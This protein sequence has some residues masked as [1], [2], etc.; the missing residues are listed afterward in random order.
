MLVENGSVAKWLRQRIANP[1][2]SVRL[3]PEPLLLKP[4]R[5]ADNSGLRR[6]FFVFSRARGGRIGCKGSAIRGNAG[7][8]CVGFSDVGRFCNRPSPLAKPEGTQAGRAWGQTFG[9]SPS[10]A[11]TPAR[12]LHRIS[13]CCHLHAAGTTMVYCG[14]KR[15]DSG[16]P[17]SSQRLTCT[18]ARMPTRCGLMPARLEG[19]VAC[20]AGYWQS[21][22]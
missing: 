20:K 19:A 5:C 2:S 9:A 21:M 11:P 17:S 13:N 12:G 10:I 8:V 14:G 15:D 4:L 3:R 16:C 1:P 22:I 7:G 6:G 18:I